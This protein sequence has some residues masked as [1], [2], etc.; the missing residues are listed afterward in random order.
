MNAQKQESLEAT[1]A[2]LDELFAHQ[3]PLKIATRELDPATELK[4]IIMLLIKKHPERTKDPIM[5]DLKKIHA[6]FLLKQRKRELQAEIEALTQ[7][8]R[9]FK[10]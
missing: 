10:L 9:E 8:I 3:E 4:K 2:K 1:R 5:V 6:R 7:Q